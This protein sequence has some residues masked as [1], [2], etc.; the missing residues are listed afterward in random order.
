VVTSAP[1][2]RARVAIIGAGPQSLAAALHLL[3]RQPDLRDDLVVVD[4]AGTWLNRWDEQFDRLDIDSLR[5]PGVHH[6]GCDPHALDEW[7][8]RHGEVSSL[9]YG[10][11]G[12]ETFRRYCHQ[13][14][15]DRGLQEQ[16]VPTG[17][18][19]LDAAAAD[20][21]LSLTDGT[22]VTARHTVLA[23]NPA[24]RRI[25][26]WVA[27]AR[28][29]QPGRVSH[30]D[31]ID[32]RG[33]DLSGWRLAVVGGGLTAGHLA[34]GAAE[35]GADVKLLIRRGL[36]ESMF[37][38]D[39]GWLGPKYLRDFE[40]ISDPGERLRVCLAARDGGSMPPWM[41]RRLRALGQQGRLEI[42]EGTPIVE[43]SSTED[44]VCLRTNDA[45]VHRFSNV[46]LATGSQ[47]DVMAHPLT[48]MLARSHPTTVLEGWPVLDPVLRWPGTTVHLLGRPAM[49]ALGPAAGNLWGGRMGGRLIA[50][51]IGHCLTEKASMQ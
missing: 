39:P 45:T 13:M 43:A 6:P 44:A 18:R 33:A 51:H 9:P 35:R 22:I 15:T 21:T 12:R 30:A 42:V 17:V 3:E 46:W 11:P 25:P 7:S 23:V 19:H 29:D 2:V 31:D 48:S 41:T 26:N 28:V 8:N 40:G 49:L 37:D 14:V 16:V 38:T 24:R 10:I 20:T 36:R 47:P 4:P 27:E 5:S 32:L 34:A 50:D 1:H